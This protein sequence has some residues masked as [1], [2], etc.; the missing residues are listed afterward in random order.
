MLSTWVELFSW[1]NQNHFHMCI[2][3]RTNGLFRGDSCMNRFLISSEQIIK[4]HQKEHPSIYMQSKNKTLERVIK[5]TFILKRSSERKLFWCKGKRWQTVVFHWQHVE[6]IIYMYSYR[7]Y[8]RW[9]LCYRKVFQTGYQSVLRKCSPLLLHE[10][11]RGGTLS[12][13]GCCMLWPN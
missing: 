2:Q 9:A 3:I 1:A 8:S 11:P 12:V 13:H 7:V 5:F 10:N 6:D 4:Q